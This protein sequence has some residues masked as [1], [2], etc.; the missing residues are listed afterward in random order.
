[1]F[2]KLF[3]AF[4]NNKIVLKDLDKPDEHQTIKFTKDGFMDLHYT[5]EGSEKKYE[6]QAKVNLMDVVK[7]II[8]NPSI[9]ENAVQEFLK[10]M[11]KVTF[12]EKEFSLILF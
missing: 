2:G 8:E 11:K 10:A 12:D 9:I 4:T 5:K 6:S 1:M 7:G 3:V